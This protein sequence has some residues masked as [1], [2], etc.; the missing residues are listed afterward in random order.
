MNYI[1]V[2]H[3]KDHNLQ[4]VDVYFTG[5]G[6]LPQREA[7]KLLTKQQANDICEAQIERYLKNFGMS[8]DTEARRTFEVIPT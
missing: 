7:A 3:C 6:W 5:S 1:V 4:P 8:D 2:A